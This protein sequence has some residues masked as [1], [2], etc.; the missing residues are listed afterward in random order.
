MIIT[1][2]DADGIQDLK[3]FLH[4]QFEMKDL[5]LL[6]YFLGLEVTTDSTG[7]HLSQTKYAYDLI[8][9]A[10]LTDSKIAPSPLEQNVRLSPFD[11]TLLTDLTIYRTLVGS[12]V[13]LTVTRLDIAYVVHLVSQFLSS[14]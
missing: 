10:G 9:K 1:G 13:Y 8:A 5:G 2:N 11:G 6:S 12:L 4:S 14:P 3:T 7:L